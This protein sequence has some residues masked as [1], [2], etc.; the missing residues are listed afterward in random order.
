MIDRSLTSTEQ[1]ILYQ[2]NDLGPVTLYFHR[3][4]PSAFS[5]TFRRMLVQYDIV[6]V[7]L[8]MKYD[9]VDDFER[10]LRK[11]SKGS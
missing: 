4:L 3:H 1:T 8:N 6:L 2:A 10:D 11:R 9:E 5:E 7:E